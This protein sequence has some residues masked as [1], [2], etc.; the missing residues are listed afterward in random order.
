MTHTA[1]RLVAVDLVLV[2]TAA[3]LPA[4]AMAACSGTGTDVNGVIHS[5]NEVNRPTGLDGTCVAVVRPD[6]RVMI[7]NGPSAG[8]PGGADA[9]HEG[10]G[11]G[12]R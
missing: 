12:A 2:L 4:S 11:P 7:Q 5:D 6:G 1:K 3:V 10:G 9:P 8:D